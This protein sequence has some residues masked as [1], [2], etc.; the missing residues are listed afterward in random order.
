VWH[1]GVFACSSRV[2]RQSLFHTPR[3][4]AVLGLG[5]RRRQLGFDAR[6]LL[7]IRVAFSFPSST[8]LIPSFDHNHRSAVRR[9]Q[10][11]PSCLRR[12]LR[13]TAGWPLIGDSPAKMWSP[14]HLPPWALFTSCQDPCSVSALPGQHQHWKFDIAATGLLHLCWSRVVTGNGDQAVALDGRYAKPC[15]VDPGCVIP[16]LRQPKRAATSTCGKE[17]CE[18]SSH[19]HFALPSS[20]R[21]GPATP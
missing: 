14:C 6:S 1:S 18:S 2:P 11:P 17:A 12:F 13:Q 3:D 15:Q 21:C 4:Q 7:V 16:E 9:E 10:R 20:S 19:P 5:W 8:S